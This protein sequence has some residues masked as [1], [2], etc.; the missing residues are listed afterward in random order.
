MP[1]VAGPLNPKFFTPFSLYALL[2]AAL[3]A[4]IVESIKFDP[5]T[6]EGSGWTPYAWTAGTAL[7]FVAINVAYD[8]GLRKL[9]RPKILVLN[10]RSSGRVVPARAL[11]LLVSRGDGASS[12][13]WAIKWHESALEWLWLIESTDP[14]SRKQADELEEVGRGLGRGVKVYREVLHNLFSIGVAKATI[15]S[16]IRRARHAGFADDEIVCDLTGMTKSVSAGM[17][18]AFVQ[19]G[20]RLTVMEPERILESGRPDPAGESFP[21]EIDKKETG[22]ED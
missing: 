18:L 20:G 21:V 19:T 9:M 1:R 2:I 13:R 6:A 15:D 17:L 11:V 16:V 22:E 10:I 7:L 8:A 12:A 14:E 5:G 4:L 3:G